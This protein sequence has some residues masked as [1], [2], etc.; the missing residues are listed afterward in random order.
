MWRKSEAGSVIDGIA[1]TEPLQDFCGRYG[2]ASYAEV[3]RI[4]DINEAYERMLKSDVKY[5]FVIVMASLK[6]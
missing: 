4:P 2:I 6:A 1:E 3:I 5:R